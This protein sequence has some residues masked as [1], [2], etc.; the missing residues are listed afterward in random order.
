V[1][2]AGIL[3]LTSCNNRSDTLTFLDQLLKEDDKGWSPPR[4][5]NKVLLWISYSSQRR[6]TN[7]VGHALARTKIDTKFVAEL[8]LA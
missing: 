2:R 4:L 6:E 7:V 3:L 8:F 5:R 1:P